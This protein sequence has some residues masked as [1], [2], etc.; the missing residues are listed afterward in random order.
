MK[1]QLLGGPL[2]GAILTAPEHT[3]W[4][5]LM[6]FSLD[7]RVHHYIIHGDFDELARIEAA[8]GTYTFTYLSP[9]TRIDDRGPFE[10]WWRDL[11]KNGQHAKR[12][13]WEAWQEVLRR[14]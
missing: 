3:P 11:D 4:P 1:A 13:A 9:D 8:D 6:H 2:D 7:R 14:F 12:L 10:A 5:E